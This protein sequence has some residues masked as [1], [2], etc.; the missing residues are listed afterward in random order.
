VHVPLP[1][2]PRDV[3]AEPAAPAGL[4]DTSPQIPAVGRAAAPRRRQTVLDVTSRR[5]MAVVAAAGGALALVTAAVPSGAFAG[6]IPALF[7]DATSASR[8][9]TAIAPV[10]D[11]T[12]AVANVHDI[13]AD[14]RD[15]HAKITE[16]VAA[17]Q[18]RAEQVAAEA[19]AAADKAAAEQKAAEEKVLRGDCGIDTSSL[20]AVKSFV[21]T[22]AQ[23]VGCQFGEPTMLGVGARENA[24]DH[25]SGKAID[26]MVDRG[27]GDELAQ[28]VLDNR[29]A[30][31]VTYVIWRQRINYGTGW[32]AME[33]RGGITANHFDH[34]H[35]SFGSTGSG[36][37]HIC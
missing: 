14:V 11:D 7:S 32:Q 13:V 27:T 24:S 3:W 4:T 31:G 35:V 22:A 16:Q 12:A 2:L 23:F 10:A 30:L 28:C 34:V 21:R 36:P 25:P 18:D 15:A 8:S 20:G 6:G 33:D 19:R 29:K 17:A 26:F 1:R 5:G 9:D 37:L